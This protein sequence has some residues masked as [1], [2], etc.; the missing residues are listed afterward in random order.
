MKGCLSLSP[1]NNKETMSSS[2]WE[3]SL[4]SSPD[5]TCAS[6]MSRRMYMSCFLGQS[7]SIQPQSFVAGCEGIASSPSTVFPMFH[8]CHAAI[9]FWGGKTNFYLFGI[10]FWNFKKRCVHAW[11]HPGFAQE[12]CETF[13]T[14]LDWK[15]SRDGTCMSW[16]GP[17]LQCHVRHRWLCNLQPNGSCQ[18]T[19]G[20]RFA[21][22]Q[23][24]KEC[25]SK[26]RVKACECCFWE[27]GQNQ[28]LQVK[29]YSS[30]VMHPSH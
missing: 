28:V 9:C 5:D 14:R 6:G 3:L 15:L 22:K 4:W 2:S 18:G 7:A 11:C 29:K 8:Y 25:G 16:Q 10:L 13:R 19:K 21:F 1:F 30:A 27:L 17:G 12:A 24:V 23:K 26:K 20:K